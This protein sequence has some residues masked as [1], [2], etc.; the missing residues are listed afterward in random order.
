M[1]SSVTIGHVLL[2]RFNLPSQGVEQLIRAREGWLRERVDLF[3][4]YCLPSVLGQTEK[5]FSW[6][7]YFDEQSPQW[8]K[9]WA[10]AHAD[11]G[12]FTPIY[13][14]DV[15]RDVLLAD[16]AGT[17]YGNETWLLTTNLDNDDG[18]AIDFVERL[19]AT[20]VAADGRTAIYLTCGLIR[21][22][23]GL[24]LREDRDNA[25]CSVVEPTEQAVTCWA[26][27]HNRLSMTMPTIA[28]GGGPAWLQVVHG[29]NV[30]N[31][32][33][34][35]L[36]TP[37]PYCQVF[38][39]GLSDLA[40]PTRSALL[41]DRVIGAPTRRTRDATRGGIKSAAMAILGKSGFDRARNVVALARRPHTS[42]RGVS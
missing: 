26:D 40:T 23:A 34:G 25:F 2:T 42:T 27:W 24:F 31:R 36:V 8:L 28:V 6:I 33:R 21:G 29:S 20:A 22:P 35:R 9:D 12:A 15:P 10:S 30:S 7:V 1:S 14:T 5:R 16:I 3:E 39:Q 17:A 4:R 41:R 32:V 19:R 37:D 18:L 11:A 38:R 13:R